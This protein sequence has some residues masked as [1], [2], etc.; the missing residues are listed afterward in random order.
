MVPAQP[1]EFYFVYEPIVGVAGRVLAF[2]MLTRRTPA[3][4]P[5]C[6]A[7]YLFSMLHPRHKV[8]IFSKQV[9]TITE[10]AAYFSDQNL[11]VSLNVDLDI[12]EFITGSPAI[13]NKLRKM[14]FV[15]LEINEHFPELYQ[16]RPQ[17]RLTQLA[18]CCPLWLD[19]FGSVNYPRRQPLHA[20]FEYIKVDKQYFWQHQNT[21]TLSLMIQQL[22]Q[23]CRGVIVEGIETPAQREGLIGSGIVGMQGYLWPSRVPFNE[24]NTFQV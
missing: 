11:L 8:Q 15:R 7:E 20:Q 22:N 23:V 17:P 10:N 18:S 4:T 24:R 1:S 14:P 21:E 5:L 19:D 12:A 13:R 2:E 16:P 3:E 9:N 6:N